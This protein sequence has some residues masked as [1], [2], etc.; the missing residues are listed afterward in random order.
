MIMDSELYL[1]WEAITLFVGACAEITLLVIAGV[2]AY[3]L[4]HDARQHRKHRETLAK[5]AITG[6]VRREVCE[7]LE[8]E[9]P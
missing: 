5:Q 2:A 6:R 9:L 4:I 3:M 7:I 8:A 1:V